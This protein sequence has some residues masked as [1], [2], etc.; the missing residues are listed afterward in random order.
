[1][2]KT[3]CNVYL[4][5]DSEKM[6]IDAK[7]KFPNIFTCIRPLSL[8]DNNLPSVPLFQFMQKYFNLQNTSVL[9]VQANSPSVTIELINDAVSIMK[10]TNVTEL[11]SIYPEDRKNNGSLWGFSSERLLNYGDPYKHKPDFYLADS[12]IDIHTQNDFEQSLIQS[13][14]STL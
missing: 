1:M 5:S 9:N 7:H 8:S 10:Y 11:L 6:L 4:N 14:S 13:E 2:V 12:S 3:G